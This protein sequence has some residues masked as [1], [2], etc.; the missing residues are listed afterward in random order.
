MG[1]LPEEPTIELES[2]NLESHPFWPL[3]TGMG[4]E[5]ELNHQWPM[6]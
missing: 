5:I 2:W 3:G 4:L 6:V 1:S